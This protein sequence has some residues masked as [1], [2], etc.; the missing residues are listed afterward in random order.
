MARLGHHEGRTTSS[1]ADHSRPI[2]R[3][4]SAFAPPPTASNPIWLATVKRWAGFMANPA[5]MQIRGPAPN[6]RYRNAAPVRGDR[7]GEAFRL[8][9][10]GLVPQRA[11][12]MHAPWGD[13]DVHVAQAAPSFIRPSLAR[14]GGGAAPARGP[15]YR[16]MSRA[17]TRPRPG[18]AAYRFRKSPPPTRRQPSSTPGACGG[19]R[20]RRAFRWR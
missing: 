17:V 9:H 18:Y 6:G 8:E 2:N 15:T 20:R 19:G 13:D 10:I 12:S 14:R 3:T 7:G 1:S 4:G 11:V 5:P 16:E